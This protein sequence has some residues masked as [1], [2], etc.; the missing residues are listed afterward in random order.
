MN[1]NKGNHNSLWKGSVIFGFINIGLVFL[2]TKLDRIILSTTMLAL[3]FVG[4][5]LSADDFKESWKE[6]NL[7]LAL[8]EAIGLVI[9]IIALIIY[10]VA[11]LKPF[12]QFFGIIL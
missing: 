11:I 8:L 12:A 1:L 10:I 9:H 6:K 3:I 5:Y 4:I 7:G 2:C